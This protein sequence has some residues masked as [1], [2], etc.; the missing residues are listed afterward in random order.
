MRK[1]VILICTTGFIIHSIVCVFK[2][3]AYPKKAVDVTPVRLSSKDFPLLFGISINPGYFKSL[4]K[5]LST[6]VSVF[7]HVFKDS[8]EHDFLNQDTIVFGIIFGA[9][10]ILMK[11][12]KK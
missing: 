9:S 5:D 2:E 1:I 10:E 12:H 11:T 7:I 6:Y 8:M 4:N 3:I